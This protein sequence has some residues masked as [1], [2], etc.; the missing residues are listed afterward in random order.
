MIDLTLLPQ[1]DGLNYAVG[2]PTE[3]PVI[4]AATRFLTQ[5]LSVY[6]ADTGRGTIFM[7]SLDQGRVKTNADIVTLVATAGAQIRTLQA[8]YTTDAILQSMDLLHAEF[9]DATRIRITVRLN[10]VAGSS[11]NQIE[12]AA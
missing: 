10:T 9:I 1:P 8:T 3:D 5:F 12:T 7:P 2:A 11:V 6:R 4:K